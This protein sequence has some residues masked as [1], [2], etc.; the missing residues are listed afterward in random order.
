M[1]AHAQKLCTTCGRS[2]DHRL[3]WKCTEHDPAVEVPINLT[4]DLSS[5]TRLTE[6]VAY[7]DEHFDG[8]IAKAIQL[9]VN[10]GLSHR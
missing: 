5:W 7:A 9:L 3:E 10:S 8:D 1:T 4:L 2:T 6:V